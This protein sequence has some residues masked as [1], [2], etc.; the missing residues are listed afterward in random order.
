MS[1][2]MRNVFA[3]STMP[4]CISAIKSIRL[5]MQ[6]LNF[7]WTWNS[8]AITLWCHSVFLDTETRRMMGEQAV[9][10]AKSVEYTSAG[11]PSTRPFLFLRILEWLC[12]L[13]HSPLTRD[14]WNNFFISVRFRFGVSVQNEFGLVRF[15]KMQFGP[16]I[17]LI[18]YLYN[19]WQCYCYVEWTVHTQLCFGSVLKRTLS[20]HWM[21]V[22]L[23]LS[24]FNLNCGLHIV[25]VIKPSEWM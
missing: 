21:Q 14:V 11:K 19:S 7:V 25:S 13:I 4:C 24:L 6:L 22:K 3:M 15:V 9:S 5:L 18:F 12:N 10:L 17:V 16:Y 1:A 2:D 8:Y 23:F 20:P